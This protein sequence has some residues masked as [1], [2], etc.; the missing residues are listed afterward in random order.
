MAKAQG[1]KKTAAVKG[2][3]KKVVARK[4]SAAT[5]NKKKAAPKKAAAPP[6][7]AKKTKTPPAKT[8]ATPK[9]APKKPV[10]KVKAV[11]KVVKKAAKKAVAKV[12]KPTPKKVAAKAVAK[13]KKAAPAAKPL[14]KAAAKAK[15]AVKAVAKTVTKVAKVAKPEPKAVTKVAPKAVAKAASKP[16]AAKAAPVAPPRAAAPV[17]P[18]PAAPRA[19]EAEKK[20]GRRARP[21]VHSSGAPAAAWLSTEKPRPASFIPAPARAEAPSA[22]A[23]PPASSDRLIRPDDVDHPAVRTVPVRIDVEQGAGRFY[24]IANPIEVSVRTGEG[25]E[26]DFRYLGGAD[27]SV[28]EIVV[29][30]EKPSPF[31]QTVFRTRKPGGARP[32]RQMSNGAL[33]A[34]VGR[35]I[36]YTVRAIN[37]YKTEL[38][39]TTIWLNVTA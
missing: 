31:T 7:P 5:T 29:E 2:A 12:A 33:P 11:A 30:F 22:V 9:A 34:A 32:H 14:A 21:R 36:Q 3:S 23:A 25:I 6:K 15:A 20:R 1:K 18:A 8:K 28:E 17:A 16:A 35:R 24:V 13:G 27:V 4:A 26:W 10:A 38:A 39:N 37:P 19:P